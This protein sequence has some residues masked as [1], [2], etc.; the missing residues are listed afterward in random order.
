MTAAVIEWAT[1]GQPMVGEIVSGDAAVVE[2]W[3]GGALVA[4]IDALGHGPEARE[5]ADI[6]VAT[7]RRKPD[8]PLSSLIRDCHQALRRSRGIA[9]TLASFD[10]REGRMSWLGIGNVESFLLRHGPVVRPARESVLLRSGIVGYQMPNPKLTTVPVARGDMLIAATDGLSG[11]FAE[12]ISLDAPL[13]EIAD[14]ILADH[15]KGTD[16]AL[17]LVA[18]YVGEGP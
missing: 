11:G 10:G 17:V 16:D 8:D 9:L 13:A 15:R 6:A 18:R 5:T 1:A 4:V 14:R 12:G 3:P 7:L 2:T